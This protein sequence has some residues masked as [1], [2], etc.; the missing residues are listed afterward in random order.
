[1]AGAASGLNARKTRA[2]RD[3]VVG[4][5]RASGGALL[6]ALPM[7]MTMEMWWLGFYMD[8]LR[9]ALLLALT[10]PVLVVLSRHSGFERTDAWRDD[11][12]DAAIAYGIGIVTSAL[13]LTVFG[14]ITPAMTADEIVGKVA[15]QAM[16]ASVGALLGRSQLGG[17]KSLP[18]EGS[19]SASYVSELFL[20]GIGA[21]F[22]SLNVAPTEETVLIAYKMTPW[23]A[24][25][26]IALSL[27]LMHG[28]VYAVE[29]KGADVS[30]PP[31]TP[32][33]SAF[34][35]FTVPGYAIALAVSLYVLWTFG[36]T[37]G[38]ALAQIAMSMIA[39]G[40]PAA[41]GAAAARL[42]I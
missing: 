9:L 4:L 34:L 10:F 35:R 36:R 21:L 42:I 14:L 29:F 8:R 39:L 15:V 30:L 33:W 13:V 24:V 23:H 37:D 18:V 19:E 31:G 40:F 3:A 11:V 32:W 22:L 6:F 12:R 25:A 5:G 2:L 7:L 27:L 1:M 41:I 38:T 28:F 16:P 17:G 26:L 20:M